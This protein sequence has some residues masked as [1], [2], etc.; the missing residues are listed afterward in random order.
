M[1]LMASRRRSL[2]GRIVLV[3]ALAAVQAACAAGPAS[4]PAASPADSPA[5]LGFVGGSSL[6]SYLA[7]RHAQALFDTAAAADYFATALREDPDNVELLQR[8]YALTAAE[9]RMKEAAELAARLTDFDSDASMAVFL[10]AV[11][12]AK[13]GDF[14]SAEKRLA[15]LPKRGINTFMAPLLTA[16]ARV[17]QGRIDAALEALTPLAS[18]SG[19]A[20]VHDFHAA[21]INDLAERRTVAEEYYRNTM[22]GSGGMTLRAVQAA[23]SFYQRTNRPNSAQDIYRRYQRQHPDSV[24]LDADGLLAAGAAGLRPIDTAKAGMAEA[25]FGAASSV[26]QGNAFDA[27]LIFARLSLEVQPDFPLAQMMVADV[28]QSQGRLAEANRV[29]LAIN[30]RA[31]VYWSAQLRIATN[32]DDMDDVEGAAALLRGL[33]AQRPDRY[34]TLVALGDLMRKRQRFAEA[35]EAYDAAIARAGSLEARH[36]A[37][38][39]SRGVSL[40][41]SKQWTRAESDFL[42]ALELEP[43]QPLVLNYLGYSWVEQ[44]ANLDQARAMIQKAVELRPD[45]GY[46]VDSLGWVLFRLGDFDA[47]AAQLERAVELRPEDP[48]IN[49]HLGDALAKVGRLDEARFQW[50]RALSLEPEADLLAQLQ[51]KLKGMP[52]A[53]GTATK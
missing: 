29:Y 25:L 30:P 51:A 53:S 22:A 41:R 31:D 28:L 37:L 7:G 16:W 11:Q 46:I 49:D 12:D 39:Y 52:V 15:A 27:A 34:D 10:L 23:G 43:D 14:A 36:W 17:G 26:R 45:D 8:A 32:L 18:N 6:G 5:P 38:L 50:Q 13:V 9:G 2:V 44:G 4:G 48:T 20:A 42:K 40:E 33:A 21:L 24:L 1:R 19:L 35:A 3:A 47:A